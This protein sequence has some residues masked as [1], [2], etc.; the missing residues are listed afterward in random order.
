MTL[1]QELAKATLGQRAK[2]LGSRG[3]PGL[4]QRGL[5]LGD[6]GCMERH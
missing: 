5:V 4:R 1:N 3:K 2:G 6:P